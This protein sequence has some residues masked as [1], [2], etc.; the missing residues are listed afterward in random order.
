MS[1]VNQ[2]KKPEAYPGAMPQE[3]A[4]TSVI[5]D[6]QAEV[7]ELRNTLKTVLAQR[8]E[9]A[10]APISSRLESM[11]EVILRKEERIA[12]AEE[13]V[14]ADQKAKNEQ[15]LRNMNL[16]KDELLAPQKSCR[17]LK[18][19]KKRKKN[20]AEDFAVYPHRFVDG[21]LRIRCTICGAF[22]Q[23]GDTKETLR[24]RGKAI[25]NHTGLSWADACNMV[26]HSTNKYSCSEIRYDVLEGKKTVKLQAEVDALKQQLAQARPVNSV[27]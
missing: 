23:E 24:R 10:P 8:Q 15:R 13:K 25:K 4:A 20:Q 19:G 26:E 17:H 11:L 3:T 18:G 5:A 22:W 27:S 16:S 6:L 7:T 21:T 1:E 14:L 9:P 12:Q 2:F